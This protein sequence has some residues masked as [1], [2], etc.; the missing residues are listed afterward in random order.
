MTDLA[1]CNNKDCIH[2]D[3]CERFKETEYY[4]YDFKA[5]CNENSNYKYIIK[6]E[7]EK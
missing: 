3:T 1:R 7:D 4:P 5:I 2:I 6:K